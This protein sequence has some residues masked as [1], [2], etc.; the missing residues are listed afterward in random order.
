M[1]VEHLKSLVNKLAAKLSQSNV[2]SLFQTFTQKLQQVWRTQQRPQRPEPI[3]DEKNVLVEAMLSF[4]DIELTYSEKNLFGLL[5]FDSFVGKKYVDGLNAILRDSN[6]D[7]SGVATAVENAR[8][9][10]VKFA[11][12]VRGL[13]G[14]L[15]ALP[16]LEE[17]ELEEDEELLEITFSDGAS[18]DNIVDFEKWIENWERIIRSFS[19]LNG[20]K[21]EASRVVFV[22]KSSAMILDVATIGAIAWGILKATDK[23]LS[24]INQYMEIRKTSEEIKRLKLENKKIASDLEKEA[25]KL[26]DRG[27][28]EIAAEIIK[29]SGR[30]VGQETK[31]TLV[32]GISSLYAFIE[33]GG[34]V[35]CDPTRQ[36]KDQETVAL[37]KRVR[38]S[39]ANVDQL[40]L[41]GPPPESR[42]K[43]TATRKKVSARVIRR[44]KP[45]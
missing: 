6:Y 33:K 8:E 36:I 43:K 37:V 45:E 44:G 35:D 26:V 40:R 19:V 14:S 16:N 20:K 13:A 11:N 41:S 29:E 15:S 39:Q 3:T 30:D 42:Q 34:R 38:D 17:L 28:K 10:F 31:A 4:D 24:Q 1:K 9:T 22:Q 7:P 27:S 18:V 21:P 12:E 25:E 5:G 23:V 2:E 32:I